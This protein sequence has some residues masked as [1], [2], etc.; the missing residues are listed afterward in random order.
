MKPKVLFFITAE[1]PYGTGETFIENEITFLSESFDK[2]I[3]VPLSKSSN[4]HRSIPANVLIEPFSSQ[5]INLLAVLRK[6]SNEADIVREVFCNALSNPFKNKILLKS[7]ER[8]L[9]I[10]AHLEKLAEKYPDNEIYHYSYWL[11]DGAI[12]IAFLNDKK[13]KFSRAHGWDVYF[14]RH[15]YNY[16]PL[17]KFLV[18]KLDQI[19]TISENGKAYLEAKVQQQ[20]KVQ[21]SRLGTINRCLFKNKNED[22]NLNI[23]SLSSVIPLKRIELMGQSIQLIDS[24]KIC[25]HHFGDGALLEQMKERFPFAKFHGH[26]ANNEIKHILQNYSPNSILINASTTEGLPVSMMEAMSFGIP[27]IGTDVGGVSEI[28]ENNVNGFLMPANPSPEI[29]AEYIN[30]YLNLTNEE[31]AQFRLNAYETWQEKFD[32]EKNYKSFIEKIKLSAH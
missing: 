21:T 29:V 5:N 23:V 1:F 4:R 24:N 9:S 14:E 6:T 26:I 13:H 3:V 30:K 27:C 19:F 20:G 15:S 11:D 22:V 28:I 17:R 7:I 18:K 8:G 31:K 32:A 25:W 16:L 2:V 12:G 10:S